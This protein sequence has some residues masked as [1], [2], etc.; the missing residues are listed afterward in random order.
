MAQFFKERT[1]HD[2]KN[3]FFSLVAKHLSM[4]IREVKQSVDYLN[5]DL[6]KNVMREK[7]LRKMKKS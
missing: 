4:P 7:N 3:R 2:A 5:S 6:L 1:E